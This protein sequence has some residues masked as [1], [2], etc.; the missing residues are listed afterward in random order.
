MRRGYIEFDEQIY[1]VMWTRSFSFGANR[2]FSPIGQ[3]Q[4][5]R[6]GILQFS[7]G[8]IDT[9]IN[10]SLEIDSKRYK[11]FHLLLEVSL[12]EGKNYG[13]K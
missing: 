11:I 1:L 3:T 5:S 12:K 13:L 6:F 9:E 8:L 4:F 2:N 7:T 10:L